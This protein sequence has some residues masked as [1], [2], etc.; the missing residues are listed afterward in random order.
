MCNMA[1]GW[2]KYLRRSDRNHV[3]EAKIADGGEPYGHSDMRNT[4]KKGEWICRNPENGHCWVMGEE[5]MDE[6]Y[7]PEDTSD[8]DWMRLQKKLEPIKKERKKKGRKNKVR[9]AD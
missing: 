9:S 7:M 5:G 4:A 3:L 8:E 6:L 1:K 2:K